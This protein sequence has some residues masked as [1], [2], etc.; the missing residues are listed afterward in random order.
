MA[1]LTFGRSYG[2]ARDTA[3]VPKAAREQIA[4]A[5]VKAKIPVNEENIRRAY[6]R[7]LELQQLKKDPG[8]AGP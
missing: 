4:E 7:V 2:E 5:L 8:A 3:V 6:A 1:G